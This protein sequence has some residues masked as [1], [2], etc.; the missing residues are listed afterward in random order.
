MNEKDLLLEFVK[1]ARIE[2]HRYLAT[3]FS[4]DQPFDNL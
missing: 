1:G 2:L 3:K 4:G